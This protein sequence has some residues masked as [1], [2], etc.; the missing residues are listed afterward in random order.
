MIQASGQ[1]EENKTPLLAYF[2]QPQWF[3]NE[4]EL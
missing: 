3:F 4:M 1:A 2:Y